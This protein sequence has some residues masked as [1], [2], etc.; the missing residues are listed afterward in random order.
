MKV[1]YQVYVKINDNNVITA[2]DS[3]G[4]LAD[5]SGWILI[6]EGSG[7]RFYLAQSNYFGKRIIDMRGI[8][9]YKLVDGK[10]VE[11]TQE[12]MDADYIEPEARPTQEERIAAL[13]EQ[14]LVTKILLGVD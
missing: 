13:E 10:S 12:E 6:D 7:D 3:S 14:L 2:V 1:I 8:Y 11:R 5:T 9:R 4:F